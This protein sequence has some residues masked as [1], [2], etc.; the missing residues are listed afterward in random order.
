[1]CSVVWHCFKNSQY[2]CHQKNSTLP[3]VG[4]KHRYVG[5]VT[6][7]SL[8]HGH[9]RWPLAVYATE[10][11]MFYLIFKYCSVVYMLFLSAD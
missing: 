8:P 4:F 1:M 2:L 5:I 3:A 11:I 6:L 9:S 10:L 7:W